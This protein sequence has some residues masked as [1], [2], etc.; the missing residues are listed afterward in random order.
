[1]NPLRQMTMAAVILAGFSLVLLA[2]GAM[3]WYAMH[4]MR[5]LQDIT[6]QLYEHPFAVSNA[7]AD[8]R[9]VLNQM[10]NEVLHLALM[11][12]D[13][14]HAGSARM[15]FAVQERQLETDLTLIRNN[16]LGEMQQVHAL[17][18]R[19]LEWK[20]IR[21]SV[22]DA[23]SRR[24]LATAARLIQEVETPK[25]A[26]IIRLVDY[27]FGY[28]VDRGKVFTQESDGRAE[29]IVGNMALLC[30]LVA[31]TV[32][33]AAAAVLWRVRSLQKDLESRASIDFLTG[34][35]NRRHFLELAERVLR[36]CQRYGKPL[37]VAV[38][39][40]DHFKSINDKYGHKVGDL[41]LQRFCEQ[42][43]KA[44][45]ESDIL[46]RVGGEEF[47]ILLPNASA[48]LAQEVINRVRKIIEQTEIAVGTM[49]PM[50][51]TASFGV[52]DYSAERKDLDALITS[53]DRALYES[54][55]AGRNR[56]SLFG[57]LS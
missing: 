39:D 32:C 23:R 47:A 42:C 4:S 24:D 8:M 54:K 41:V 2:V 30:G 16:F 44:L 45:R 3:G 31:V 51:F 55:K 49:A 19:L 10:H 5:K 26:E 1:M 12:D 52:A 20:S 50:H 38:V 43:R 21:D 34:V 53:A 37:S 15:D 36:S 56:V 46:G 25:F 33:A 28:A 22:L 40:L 29:Q 13:D 11:S 35:P 7:A 27:I 9:G 6:L 18:S 17:R 48:E 14:V 57:E